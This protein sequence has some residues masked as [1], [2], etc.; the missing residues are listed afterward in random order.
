MALEVVGKPVPRV[1]GVEKV[2]GIDAALAPG[3]PILHPDFN[4]Y[5]GV[6]ETP[7]PGPFGGHLPLKWPSNLYTQRRHDRGDLDAGFAE[8][9]LIVENTYYTQRQH[10]GYLE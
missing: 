4:S 1:D 8:A 6:T 9:D 5:P 2:T 3:A 7:G 10:Q